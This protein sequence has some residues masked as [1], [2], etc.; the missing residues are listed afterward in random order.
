MKSKIT[1]KIF[2]LDEKTIDKF[3][4]LMQLSDAKTNSELLTWL[5]NDA[6]EKTNENDTGSE[7]QKLTEQIQKL[8]HIC[9]E[10]NLMGYQT[11]DALNSLI[12]FYAPNNQFASADTKLS[13][14]APHEFF[15]RSKENYDAKLHA[16]TVHS[17]GIK[18]NIN[19][20]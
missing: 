13:S 3:N 7:L 20:E 14:S 17:R 16:A 11:R 4:R 10:N 2:S 9:N 18:K 6:Y 15:A 1:K 8:V 5:I 19:G 12:Y